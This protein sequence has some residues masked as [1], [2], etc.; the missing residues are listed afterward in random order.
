M[1]R[2]LVRPSGIAGR[3]FNESAGFVVVIPNETKRINRLK[4]AIL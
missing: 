1:C 4:R 2:E 3:S